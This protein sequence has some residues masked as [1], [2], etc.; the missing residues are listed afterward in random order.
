M[1]RTVLRPRR[2]RSLLAVSAVVRE[3]GTFLWREVRRHGVVAQYH[4]R[5]SNL[6]VHLRH[7]TPDL[8]GMIEMFVHKI[9]EPP[10][11][12]A[13]LLEVRNRD[14]PLRVVD[15]GGNIGLFPLYVMS[16]FP[17][18][19][20]TSVE[21]DPTNAGLLSLTVNANGKQGQWRLLAACAGAS[22]GWAP[23]RSGRYLESHV[24]KDDEPGGHAMPKIDILPQL[25]NADWVKID[26]E[27]GEWE[28]LSDPRFAHLCVPV[29]SLEYHRHLCPSKSPRALVTQALSSAGYSIVPFRE[30]G[31][32]LGEVWAWR[33]Q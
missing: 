29:I 20:L 15:L 17:D 14:R 24:T 21:P 11:H 7:D 25:N 26:I 30:R 9:Y 32:G 19:M 12:I 16:L 18:A 3:S 23:F 1:L 5:D 8:G 10:A 27:G 28:L 22:A 4:L 31:D 13:A 33:A 6:V 2:W